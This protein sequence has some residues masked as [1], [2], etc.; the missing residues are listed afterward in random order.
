MKNSNFKAYLSAYHNEVTGSRILLRVSFPDGKDYR[1]LIDCGY[2]QE[3]QYRH[4][5]YVDDIDPT[6]IDAI[7]V[8]HNHIDHTGLLPKMVKQGYRNPIYMTEITRELLPKYL[9]DSADQQEDNAK[10]LQDKFPGD[11]WK[12]NVP[13]HSEDVERTIKLCRGVKYQKALEILPGVRVTFFVNGHILGASMILVQCTAY[14]RKPLN[15][16]FTGD[17][18]LKNPFYEVPELPSWLKKTELIMVHESTYG[19]TDSS[20]IKV[21]FRSNLLEAFERGQDILIGAFAQARMQE[22]LFELKKMQDECLIPK[23]YKIYVDGSLGIK[24]NFAYG[25][26]L[27]EFNPEKSHFMPSD[28][29]IVDPKSRENFFSFEGKKILVTTSGMLSNGP[30]KNYVPMF[31]ERENAMIHLTGYAAEETLARTLL[32]AKDAEMVL[33]GNK[34][35]RKRALIKTTRE[36]TS[37]ATRDEM[38]GFINKF[39][40]IVFLA[41]NHGASDVKRDFE[42]TIQSQCPRVQRVDILNR[43]YVYCIYQFG[44]EGD[45]FSNV[46]V[47]R[48]PA[49]MQV[50]SPKDKNY[51]KQ[52]QKQKRKKRNE[53][54]AQKKA[55][56]R[57]LKLKPKHRP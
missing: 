14:S 43:D 13:Y 44:N 35:Y 55:A 48:M 24:T 25:E 21:C 18:K 57:R 31:L 1:I 12:F 52:K 39:A 9:M 4:L 49:K 7:L 11:E 47:K 34:P 23:D 27:R 22:I 2:F 8:T 28:I 32:E 42:E 36:K 3:I 56:K 37:H 16:L 29:H 45:K 19:T 6:T 33:I 17:Y 41:I 54:K 51:R 26:I 5:N 50:L 40:N 20:S 38:L 30:A 15:F 46:V 53:E 10:Y